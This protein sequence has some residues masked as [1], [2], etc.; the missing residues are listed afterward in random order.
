MKRTG[1]II[2]IT[3][4]IITIF[5]IIYF[6]PLVDVVDNETMTV[7]PGGAKVSEWPLYIGIY[8]MFVGSVFFVVSLTDI[9]THR[10]HPH[11]NK[12]QSI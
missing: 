1:I 5:C 11:G 8:T 4:L 7:N 6:R 9:K 12:Q 2:F 3:G 10:V